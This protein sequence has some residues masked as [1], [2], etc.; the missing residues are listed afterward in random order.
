MENTCPIC[1]CDIEK[2]DESY[3]CSN[4]NCKT[5]VCQDC[6]ESLIKFSKK[7][8][9]LPSCPQT[10]CNGIYILRNLKGLTKEI[11]QEYYLSCLNTFLK[12]KGDSI[13]KELEQKKIIEK[14]RNEKIK[15]I[16]DSYPKAIYLTAKIV[17]GSRLRKLN[18]R[19][20]KIVKTKLSLSN[21]KC[22]FAF[23][24]GYLNDKY[25]CMSCDTK[26]CKKCEKE[27]KQNHKCLQNDI[28]SVNV[29]NNLVKCPKCLLP[30]FK[31]YGCDYMKCS[32]CNTNFM[33]STGQ[34]GGVGNNHNKRTKINENIKMSNYLS[35]NIPNKECK[36]LLVEIEN[37]KPRIVSKDIILEPIKIYFQDENKNEKLI[38]RKVAQKLNL[39]T[40]CQ[41]KIKE[42]NYHLKIIEDLLLKKSLNEQK[43]IIIKRNL[44]DFLS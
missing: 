18:R 38:G 34:I 1:F 4:H 24:D 35:D 44:N 6:I 7:E 36:K 14:I 27:S 32:N 22:M 31:S 37:M 39:Y 28:D 13:K 12:S 17:F 33:Y 10:G 25:I 23:C 41:N 40:L 19:K 9:V 11:I 15:F 43:L 42:Y 20:Q 26:F 21:K 5:I 29:I 30:I 3:H 2:N 8:N 16:Q